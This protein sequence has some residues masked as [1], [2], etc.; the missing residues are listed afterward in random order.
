MRILVTGGSGSVGRTAVKWLVDHGHT[1]R[2]IGR[3]EGVRLEGAEYRS[4]DITDFSGLQRQMKGIEGVVHLAAIPAPQLGS[5]EEIFRINCAGTFNVYE[6]AVR[7]GIARV[8][9]A[10]SINALGFLDGVTEWDLSYLPVD[11]EHPTFTTDAYSF[12]K[13][14]LEDTAAYYWRRDGVSGVSL[15]LPG[16]YPPTEER[17]A[18]LEAGVREAAE[19]FPKLLSLPEEEKARFRAGLKDTALT[20]RRKRLA[21]RPQGWGRIRD[22]EQ[23]R[24]FHGR[25]NLFTN[26]DARD[27]AQA[28]EKGLLAEYQG[29][30]PLFINDSHNRTGMESRLLAELFYPDVALKRP[31]QGTESLVSI[32]RAREL[33]AFEPRFSVSRFFEEREA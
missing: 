21:E 6:A 14:V 17:L 23:M 31:L 24:M 3:K 11:E 33:L 22:R 26:V 19:R 27:S 28:I 32:G 29:S 20:V 12:S 8:V 10:S 5:P 13:Q 9:S 2:V 25:Y 1:V 15:R 18:L 16:V 7:A 4:C 30:H